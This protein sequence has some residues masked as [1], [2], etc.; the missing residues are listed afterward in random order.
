MQHEESSNEGAC[1][2]LW[3]SYYC[4]LPGPHI[5][6]HSCPIRY[7]ARPQGVKTLGMISRIIRTIV[8]NF[9]MTSSSTLTPTGVPLSNQWRDSSFNCPFY[10]LIS[11]FICAF[12]ALYITVIPVSN[13]CK[14]ERVIWNGH[15]N[16]L[17]W[18]GMMTPTE[19][20]AVVVGSP[21]NNIQTLY[22]TIYRL[23][24]YCIQII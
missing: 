3:H 24:T 8:T 1:H 22:S 12:R 11:S 5:G 4:Y 6:Q 9:N 15:Q 2:V 7:S 18:S 13:N 21:W 19:N 23:V 16:K 17:Y 20:L 10:F 14:L